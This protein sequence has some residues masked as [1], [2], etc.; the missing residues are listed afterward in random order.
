M[1]ILIAEDDLTSR[2]ILGGYLKKWGYEVIAT[3]DGEQAWDILEGENCPQLAILDW[4]MPGYNGVELCKK[5]RDLNRSPYVYIILLTGKDLQEDIVAGLGS[6]AD[7]YLTKP[8][9]ISELK[10]RL[11]V[12]RRIIELEN[13][14]HRQIQLV[15]EANEKL[16]RDLEAAANV[17]KS[18]LPSRVPD[19][20]NYDFSWFY[21]P[22]EYLGGDMLNIVEYDERYV[23]CYVIDVSGHGVPSALLSVT[24]RN[25]LGHS[26]RSSQLYEV[27]TDPAAVMTKLSQHFQDL[28]TSTELYFTMLYGVLDTKEHTFKFTQAGHPYPLVNAKDKAF[29]E[30]IDSNIPV[31]FMATDYTSN[32]I[33][34][35]PGDAF[36]VY[37]DGITEAGK[38]GDPEQYGL[39]RF[40]TQI[41]DEGHGNTGELKDSIEVVRDWQGGGGFIDDVSLIRV[42]RKA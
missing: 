28:L 36:Y 29:E 26:A 31:G 32:E 20:P 27:L 11:Q 2:K 33:S 35:E 16:H 9:D 42:T 1:Q 41:A 34:L 8:F 37:T 25:Q 10:E 15:T 17:Q 39:D 24:V 40:L 13:Q 30:Q 21:E 5:L 22:S 19:Q 14:L 3:A 12:G 23:I 4:E 6:G 38:E 7:D 18:L